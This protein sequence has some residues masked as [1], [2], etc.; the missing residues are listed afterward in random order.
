MKMNC[1][2]R[3]T[4]LVLA[5]LAVLPQAAGAQDAADLMKRAMAAQTERLSGVE[6]VTIVQEMMGMEM[7]MF[8]EKRD[9]EGTPIL[10]PVSVTMA[11]MTNAV[12]QDMAGAD[13]SNPFQEEWVEHTRFVGREELDGETVLVFTID[14]FSAIDLPQMPGAGEG[15]EDF[16]PKSFRYSMT[17]DD[18]LLREVQMEGEAKQD[19]GTLAPVNM[20]MF[21][22]D[23]REVDGYIHPFVTRVITEGA[24][25]AANVDQEELQQQLDQLQAQLDQMPEAQ[26][27]MM[28]Q[29]MGPQIEQLKKMLGGDGAMEMT[30]T[31]KELKVNAGGD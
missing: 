18:F 19:D 30:I 1:V 7:S 28:E 15:S 13:W 10:V 2:P 23:Y 22:E 12:P 29:M 16:N 26:R 31:V 25:E 6:N 4:A 9:A 17:E 3:W 14:D 20:N 21:L 27:A 5:G 8:M 11:G 24:L